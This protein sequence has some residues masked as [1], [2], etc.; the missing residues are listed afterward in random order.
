MR[1]H[2]EMRKL[3]FFEFVSGSYY[4]TDRDGSR[5]ANQG[6]I[7]GINIIAGRMIIIINKIIILSE[8]NKHVDNC[9]NRFLHC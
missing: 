1:I 6:S 4:I 5:K 8:M 3:N 2:Y 9:F 7:V